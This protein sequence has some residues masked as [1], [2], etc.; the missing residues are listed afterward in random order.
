[1]ITELASHWHGHHTLEPSARSATWL[2]GSIPQW[3]TLIATVA[4]FG[5]A[6]FLY[7]RSVADKRVE[8]PRLVYVIPRGAANPLDADSGTVINN[9]CHRRRIH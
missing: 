9:R 2:G 1:M 5:W 7:R 6:V 4:A 3:L 8:L